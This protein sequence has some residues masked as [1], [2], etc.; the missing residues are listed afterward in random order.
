MKLSKLRH[1]TATRHIAGTTIP[2]QN[3]TS[4]GMRNAMKK[5]GSRYA[6]ESG[7]VEGSAARPRLDRPG[8]KAVGRV[9]KADGGISDAKTH[10]E[11]LKKADGGWTGEGDSG[12]AKKEESAAKTKQSLDAVGDSIFHGGLG[13]AS[14]LDAAL[15]R[16]KLRA[17]GAAGALVNGA[18]A[19][20][21]VDRSVRLSNEAK[22]ANKEGDEAEGRKSGGRAYAKGGKLTTMARD[23]IKTSNF[24]LSGRRYP[25]EDKG[26]AKAA[27]SRVSA[28]GSPEEKAEVRS[29]V[30]RKYPNMSKD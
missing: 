18:V 17:L 14:G 30:H 4:F 20:M 11:R 29:K 24:A 25:I 7:D 19:K 8:R 26:H 21:G 28:N 6:G 15:A 27:L 12:K 2:R 5:G 1:A 22:A 9:C 3:T 16:G 10:Q 13:V 23:H